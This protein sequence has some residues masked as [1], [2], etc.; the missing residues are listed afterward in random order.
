MT[1]GLIDEDKTKFPNY[2]LMKIAGFHKSKG[3][4]VEFA[5]MFKKYDIIYYSKVFTFSPDDLTNYNTNKILTGGTGYANFNI[6][7]QEIEDSQPDFTLYKCQHAYGFTTRGC[8]RK[9]EFC[10]VPKKEGHIRPV[11]NVWDIMQNKKTLILMD[12]NILAHEHG[13]TQIEY[14]RNRKIP[15]DFN[16]GLDCR[17]IDKAICKILKDVKFLKPLRLSCDSIKML[18]IIF[19]A[20]QQLRWNNVLPIRYFCYVIVKDL[21]EGLEIVKYLKALYLDVFVQPFRAYDNTEPSEEIK[22][23][24]RFVNIKSI[25]KSI[26]WSEYGRRGNHVL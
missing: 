16:Q 11:A 19:K 2:A 10:I 21:K 14:I 3:D 13:I 22:R 7:S 18:P 9:Y 8:I 15:V 17:L 4:T 20:V 1:I 6:L 12:N 24:A 26:T 23:F 5:T 25:F